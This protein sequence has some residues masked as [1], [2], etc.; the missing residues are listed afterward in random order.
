MNCYRQGIQ[1]EETWLVRGR[2]GVLSLDIQLFPRLSVNYP[3]A[4]A[5]RL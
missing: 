3:E 1:P 5:G 4:L 2:G